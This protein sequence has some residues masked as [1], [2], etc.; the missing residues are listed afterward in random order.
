MVVYFYSRQIAK[1]QLTADSNEYRLAKVQKC[2]LLLF[3]YL[4]N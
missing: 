2:Y 1:S 4:L 3:I